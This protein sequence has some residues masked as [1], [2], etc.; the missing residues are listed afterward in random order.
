[1]RHQEAWRVLGVGDP[2]AV[3]ALDPNV[4]IPS[5]LAEDEVLVR[6]QAAA[7]NPMC[8]PVSDS[9]SSMRLWV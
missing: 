5:E 7:L 1:M 4:P 3:L 2:W 8:V 6:V 9:G